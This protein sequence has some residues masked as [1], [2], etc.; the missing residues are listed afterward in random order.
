MPLTDDEVNEIRSILGREPT[1]EELAMFEAQWSEHCSYKSSRRLLKLLPTSGKGVLIGPGRDAPAVEVFPGIA[2]VFKI[3]SHNHPSAVDPYNGAATG[4]GGVVRDILT[5]GAKPIA[6]LDMLYLGDPHDARARWLIKGIVRGISD[7]GN[8]IGIPTV[9]GDTWFDSSFNS[10]PLVNVACVGIVKVDEIVSQKPSPGDL[11]MIIGAP[12]GQEGLLG[13]SFASKPL[14]EKPDED[15]RAVQIANPLMEKILIDAILELSRGKLVKYIKDLGGGG[16]TTAVAEVASDFG[17]GAE[18]RLENLHLK[19]ELSPLEILVSESQER[20]MLVIDRGKLDEV[21]GVLEKYDVPMSVIGFFDSSGRIRA[22]YKD[23]L[24]ADVPARELA[25]PRIVKRSSKPPAEPTESLGSID[26]LPEIPV[27]EAFRLVF[28][29]PNVA[30]KRWIYEQYDHEVG[31]RT[32]VKPGY[33]DAAV[34][35]LDVGDNRGIAV[36]GDANPRYTSID[37][38]RG[39]A[40]AVAEC[41]RNLVSVGSTP[42]AFVDE[43]NAGNPE[44]PEH[45]WYFEMMVKGIAWMADELGVPVVGG[46]VSF[47]NEDHR[48]RQVK[49]T[50]T[51]VGVGAVEDISKATTLNFK[52]PGSAVLVVGTT[53][54]ELGG[55]EYL[56]R[57][58]GLETGSIPI[59]R[60]AQEIR[61]ASYIA[62]LAREGIATSVHD[63]S[64]GG[65]AVAVAEMAILGGLGVEID[66]ENIPNRGCSR[67]DEVLFSET[68]ARYI[69]EVPRERVKEALQIAQQDGVVVAIIGRVIGK[70]YFLVRSG[71]RAI[72]E[73]SLSDLQELYE[74]SL[75]KLLL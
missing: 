51:I 11:I 13:S 60:P 43:P 14:S 61:N 53:F 31:V 21:L 65:L 22:Y 18:L 57:V 10:Q 42:I 55:T 4:I 12:T 7:Y 37:P 59:P 34:L 29:S 35:R 40:N 20:M 19:V 67:I 68:Q 16:L 54:P 25:R 48:G 75:Y 49:P 2:V 32:V 8:R 5:L 44:K 50:A 74:G 62:R 56:A 15:I 24:V 66:V 71:S 3:E 9:A 38:F 30:S 27:S 52:N 73:E 36:K 17:L 69:I 70:E 46:K 28:S 47:Y 6:L 64:L 41:Y 23:R 45:F 33:G 26:H 1:A 39:A 63:I 58:F 72:L